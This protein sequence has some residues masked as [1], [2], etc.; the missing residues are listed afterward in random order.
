[1]MINLE[2]GA[3]QKRAAVWHIHILEVT[4]STVNAHT[5]WSVLTSIP[6]SSPLLCRLSLTL[7]NRPE[8][9]ER[10]RD[11]VSLKDCLHRIRAWSTD[12]STSADIESQGG[13]VV[14]EGK[15]GKAGKKGSK[16]K[17][18]QKSGAMETALRYFVVDRG[19][20]DELL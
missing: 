14:S 15:P 16:A 4:E 3:G 13:V 9:H 2:A 7:F 11:W 18:A 1:M 20:E 10:E 5:K 6:R 12:P 19:L 17:K 8:A